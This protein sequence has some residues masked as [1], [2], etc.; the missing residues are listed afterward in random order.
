[1]SRFSKK[2]MLGQQAEFLH[3]NGQK[4]QDLIVE[5]HPRML[6]L[7]K[8]GFIALN[9]LQSFKIISPEIN[10]SETFPEAPKL[11]ENTIATS[12]I[13]P[14]GQW[15]VSIIC[16]DLAEISKIKT[17]LNIEVNS[18]YRLREVAKKKIVQRQQRKCFNCEETY[19]TKKMKTPSKIGD[20]CGKK[21]CRKAYT[22]LLRQ[23]KE[24]NKKA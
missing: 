2:D 20:F 7:E 22:I 4:F 23:D 24:L 14:T 6:K 11:S 1:M 5:V 16:H 17:L 18:D 3:L 12:A 10:I 19:F 13:F 9:A 15:V 21:Q 8:N